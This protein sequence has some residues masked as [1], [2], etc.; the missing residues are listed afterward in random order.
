M[1]EGWLPKETIDLDKPAGWP[2]QEV[3]TVLNACREMSG[4][5]QRR[6]SQE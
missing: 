4:I 1:E 6:E 3:L 2:S 5:P